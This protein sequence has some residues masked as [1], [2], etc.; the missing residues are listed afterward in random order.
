[1]PELVETDYPVEMSEAEMKRYEKMKS[2]LVLALPDGDIT[3][4]N[5]AALSGKLC[6]M[7]PDRAPADQ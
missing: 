6:Q 2:D 1:M 3:A 4:A 7:A 5:A